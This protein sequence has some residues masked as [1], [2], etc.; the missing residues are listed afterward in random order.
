MNLDEA[1]KIYFGLARELA[2]F[3][4]RFEVAGSIRRRAESPG[5]ID[6]VV[7]PSAKHPR[8]VFGKKPFLNSFE[9]KLSELED[10]HQL[11][12]LAGGDKLKRYSLYPRDWG[13]GG[14]L[15]SVKLQVTIA[16]LDNWAYW[17]LIRTG[18]AEFSH[19]IVTP[20]SKGGAIPDCV[21]YKDFHL[22]RVGEESD[23][24]PTPIFT[25]DETA[26]FNALDLPYID[27]WDRRPRWKKA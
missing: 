14:Y 4:E 11:N 26:W 5:D 15:N 8:P 6:L 27:P 13:V 1:R 21:V 10:D 7:I 25:P 22:W 2:P 17:L 12:L 20:Q 18:P 16:T 9:Q 3:C 24:L 23:D 19:W